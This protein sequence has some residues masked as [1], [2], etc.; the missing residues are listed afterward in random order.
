LAPTDQKFGPLAA[1][2]MSCDQA[3]TEDRYLAALGRVARWS[4]GSDALTLSPDDK[5]PVLLFRELTETRRVK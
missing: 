3:K 5:G 2:K 4:L 1:T